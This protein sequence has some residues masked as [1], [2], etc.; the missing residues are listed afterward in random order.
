M[1]WTSYIFLAFALTGCLAGEKKYVCEFNDHSGRTS[2]LV[3]SNNA[4]FGMNNYPY[5]CT[6][7][8]NVATFGATKE[9]CDGYI[10]A[11]ASEWFVINFDEIAG[12][13]VVFEKTKSATFREKYEYLCKKAEN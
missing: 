2:L 1:K 6:S 11:D 7:T 3:K 4:F 10:G 8:G 13:L 9:S 5:K 12:T